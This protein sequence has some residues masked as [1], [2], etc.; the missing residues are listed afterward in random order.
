M[1]TIE[2]INTV[3]GHLKNIITQRYTVCAVNLTSQIVNAGAALG[4]CICGGAYDQETQ[5]QVLY[6]E[7]NTII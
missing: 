1:N 6:T 4:I 7:N 3:S 5:T 2:L